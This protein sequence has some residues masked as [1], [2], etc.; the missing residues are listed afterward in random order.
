MK[1]ILV[2]ILCCFCK[3]VYADAFDQQLLTAMLA[4]KVPVVSYAIIEH[5][6]IVRVEILSTDPKI[7]TNIV[8]ARPLPSFPKILAV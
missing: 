1:N 5:H 6:R 4:Y 3:L 2:L 7:K 8:T